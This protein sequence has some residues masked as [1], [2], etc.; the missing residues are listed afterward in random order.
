MKRAGAR[1]EKTA[2]WEAHKLEVMGDLLFCKFKQNKQLY[3]SLLNTRPMNLIEAT[4]DVFWGVGCLFGS[5]ALDERSWEGQNNLG[6][7][8]VKVRDFFVKELEIGQGSI[9]SKDPEIK[10]DYNWGKI[11]TV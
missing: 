8:L 7:L 10:R 6:K 3:Y 11:N 4:L 5:I 2:F 9:Q 1:I